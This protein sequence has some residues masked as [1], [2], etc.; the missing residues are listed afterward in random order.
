MYFFSDRKQLDSFKYSTIYGRIRAVVLSLLLAA[1]FISSPVLPDLK[2]LESPGLQQTYSAAV[3]EEKTARAGLEKQR[4]ELSPAVR[5]EVEE[6]L[7]LDGFKQ[8]P[9]ADP[10]KGKLTG[11][12]DKRL[13]V[14]VDKPGVEEAA[15]KLFPLMEE[16][17]R[18]EKANSNVS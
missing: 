8:N 5:Q 3:G 15:K 13:L 4:A 11:D 16:L 10:V 18:K 6:F 14:L 17:G 12:E 7:L 2:T 1:G 9:G